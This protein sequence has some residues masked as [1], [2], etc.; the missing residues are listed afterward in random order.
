VSEPLPPLLEEPPAPGRG[1]GTILLVEDD[2]A[3]RE[4]TR[5]ILQ[6][7]GY[8]VVE[9]AGGREAFGAIER[10]SGKVDLVVTDLV[11]PGMGGDEFAQLLE[12][13]YPDV[14]V[15]YT[16]GHVE[17][18]VSVPLK[19]R[20]RELIR[21]PFKSQDLVRKVADLLDQ[22]NGASLEPAPE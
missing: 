19:P 6:L 15:L 10:A 7:S 17:R 13:R 16:S 4:L 11:M 1:E 9:S 18:P 14:R 12:A 5:E 22:R 3:V 2:A 8:R 21:K 20:Y